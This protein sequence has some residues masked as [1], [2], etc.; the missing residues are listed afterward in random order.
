MDRTF[1][2][3]GREDVQYEHVVGPL[4]IAEA[5]EYWFHYAGQAAVKRSKGAVQRL[6]TNRDVLDGL[7]AWLV[8]AL[9]PPGIPKRPFESSYGTY[10]TGPDAGVLYG[11]LLSLLVAMGLLNETLFISTNYD[12]LL[13]RSMLATAGCFPDY[14]IE[15]FVDTPRDERACI[16]LLKVHGSLN[17]RVCDTCHLLRNFRTAIVWPRSECHDCGDIAARPMLIRPTLLKDFRHRVWQDVWR[18]AGRRLSR[19]TRWIFIGYSLPL[20]DVWMLRLVT[21]AFRTA[22]G[23]DGGVRIT[24]VDPDPDVHARYRVLFPNAISRAISFGEWLEGAAASG[25]LD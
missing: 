11:R 22:G 14:R 21:Q 23:H 12:I 15:A 3:R 6:V 9:D 19:A 10:Y 18:E 5:E 13:D 16:P 17:W 25:S 7:D 20:A 8:Y 1:P 4:E 24:I 2:G